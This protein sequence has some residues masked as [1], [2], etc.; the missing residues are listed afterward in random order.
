[1]KTVKH[2]KTYTFDQAQE[3]KLNAFSR[4]IREVLI[5]IIVFIIMAFVIKQISEL[6]RDSHLRFQGHDIQNP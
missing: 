4:K 5:L 3:N 6:Q 1:M 2:N